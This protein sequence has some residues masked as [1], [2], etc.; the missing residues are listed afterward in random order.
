MSGNPSNSVPQP[1]PTREPRPQDDSGTFLCYQ[2]SCDREADLAKPQRIESTEHDPVETVVTVCLRCYCAW[3]TLSE[4]REPLSTT[5][6]VGESV[7]DE[8]EDVG[9]SKIRLYPRLL[10]NIVL[11]DDPRGHNP[12]D[13]DSS[14]SD[15]F[16]HAGKR[17]EELQETLETSIEDQLEE[18]DKY[19]PFGDGTNDDER[20]SQETTFEEFS[21]GRE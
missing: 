1:Q 18:F 9:W 10:A 17:G 13:G 7:A 3:E 4:T 11:Y 8:F 19:G 16:D 20:P 5:V 14:L 2:E 21:D 15:I 6:E 12:P